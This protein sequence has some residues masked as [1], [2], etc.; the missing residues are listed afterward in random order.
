M[1]LKGELLLR[2]SLSRLA[3]RSN[4]TRIKRYH[5]VDVYRPNAVDL[6]NGSITSSAGVLALV[7]DCLCRFPGLSDAYEVHISHSDPLHS[8]ARQESNQSE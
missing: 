7:N 8:Y 2:K 4:I 5:I 1:L 3:P 6:E